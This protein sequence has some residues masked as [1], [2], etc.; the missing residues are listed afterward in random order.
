MTAVDGRVFRCQ[1]SNYWIAVK[2]SRPAIEAEQL[3]DA[4]NKP[5]LSFNWRP[6]TDM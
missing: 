4:T 5:K 6:E 3:H 2:F 1:V